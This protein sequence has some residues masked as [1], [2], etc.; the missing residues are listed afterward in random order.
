MEDAM[1]TCEHEWIWVEVSRQSY[2]WQECRKCG[3]SRSDNDTIEALRAKL[4]EAEAELSALRQRE[5]AAR[6]ALDGLLGILVLRDAPVFEAQK[7]LL[8]LAERLF[9]LKL[10]RDQIDRMIES[11]ASEHLRILKVLAASASAES[12]PPAGKSATQNGGGPHI[13]PAALQAAAATATP[14]AATGRPRPAWMAEGLTVKARVLKFVAGHQAA[15]P[16]EVIVRAMTHV[17]IDEKTA[18]QCCYDLT[19][20]KIGWMDRTN[21]GLVLNATGKDALRAG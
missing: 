14:A 5:E 20:S 4:A 11:C 15:V 2:S 3:E 17:G 12:A 13:I 9:S 19:S 10:D 16:Q 8:E 7:K 6:S 1:A 18:D 21:A